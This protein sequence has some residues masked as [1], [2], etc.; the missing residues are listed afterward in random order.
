M[1]IPTGFLPSRDEL[2]EL[3]KQKIVVGGFSNR[4]Y[5]SSTEVAVDSA[6][7]QG[8]TASGQYHDGK[9]DKCGLRAVRA[10]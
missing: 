3:N 9:Q 5:W 10:F 2:N 7:N 6:W 1:D 4:R 8:F